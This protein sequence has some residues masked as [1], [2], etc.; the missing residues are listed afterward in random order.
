MPTTPSTR[1]Y[2]TLEY[3]QGYADGHEATRC[4]RANENPYLAGDPRHHGWA[5][6]IYDSWSIRQVE[7]AR[8]QSDRVE[9]RPK[10][11]ANA[12]AQAGAH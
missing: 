11:V 8:R 6:A 4:G 10:R 1:L 2:L 9:F 5:D 7:I 12:F 3:Q